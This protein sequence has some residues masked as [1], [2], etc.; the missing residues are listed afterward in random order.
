LAA[1][2]QTIMDA[3]RSRGLELDKG[4]FLQRIRN[5]VPVL[6]PLIVN[7]FR[8]SIE[9]AEAMEVKAFGASKKRTSLRQLKMR[10]VDF[11][12][13]LVTIL[14]LAAAIYIRLYI[15]I[16]AVIPSD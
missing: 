10:K 2:L 3:Q 14:L 8:R 13:L 16:P 4:N 11:I 1:E 7:I 12:F 6:V 15:P 9:L 5:F